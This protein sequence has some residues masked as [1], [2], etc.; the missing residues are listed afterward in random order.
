MKLLA[1]VVGVLLAAT[2]AFAA[3][4]DGKWTGTVTTP[5]GEAP[6]EFEFK[7]DGSTLTGTA[8]APDGSHVAIKNGK[9]D[10]DTITYSATFDLGGM[11]FDFTY[12]G[13]VSKN[14]IK[15]TTEVLGM[16]FEFVVK[17]N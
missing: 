13:I 9:I 2:P 7:A 16:P 5:M 8:R 6:V 15:V 17:K 3:D 10:G 12:K 11:S 1:L 4:V 14:E